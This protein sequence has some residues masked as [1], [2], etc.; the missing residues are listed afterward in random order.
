MSLTLKTPNNCTLWHKVRELVHLSEKEMDAALIK[1][2]TFPAAFCGPGEEAT[3][4]RLVDLYRRENDTGTPTAER[5]LHEEFYEFI[6]AIQQ[7]D[8]AAA[9]KE[10]AQVVQV[11]A[12]IYFH[13]DHYI[14]QHQKKEA[15]HA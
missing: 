15:D 10:L 7:G 3:V 11:C 5:V 12:R 13:L 1:H 9:A 4:N 2:P 8:K 14:A 6:Q